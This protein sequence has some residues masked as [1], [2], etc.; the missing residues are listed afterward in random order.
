[1]RSRTRM[2]CAWRTSPAPAWNSRACCGSSA[3]N[4]Q[5]SRPSRRHPTIAAVA[6]TWQEVFQTPNGTRPVDAA[7]AP[8]ARGGF[9]RR[10]RQNLSKSREA[11]SEELR[12][13]FTGP[14][15]DETWERL[16][17]ALIY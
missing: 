16:E 2:Q 1:P 13:T 3:C 12:A 7:P 17:E 11:L 9:F 8:E 15:N 6:K 14:L 5:R 4:T 10:L